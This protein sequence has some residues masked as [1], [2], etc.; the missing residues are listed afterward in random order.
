M[1]LDQNIVTMSQIRIHNGYLIV[2]LF[3]FTVKLSHLNDFVNLH[4]VESS[5]LLTV[6]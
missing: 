4:T 3:F 5:V 6:K 2:F 1:V